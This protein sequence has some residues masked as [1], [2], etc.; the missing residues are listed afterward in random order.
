MTHLQPSGINP[1][2]RTVEGRPQNIGSGSCTVGASAP[3]GPLR[4]L[5]V[6]VEDIAFLPNPLSDGRLKKPR[7]RLDLPGASESDD[8]PRRVR[9][10]AQARPG[11]RSE[12]RGWAFLH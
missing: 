7:L 8:L 10:P 12:T 6:K 5:W 2:A 11:A 3:T 9:G 1:S 4:R